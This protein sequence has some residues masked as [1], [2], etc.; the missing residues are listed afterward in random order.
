MSD[1]TQ[2]VFYGPKDALSTGNPAKLIKGT[3]IDAE[4]AAISTAVASK[5][6]VSGDTIFLGNGTAGAPSLAFASDV[7]TGA[8]RIGE[9][10][11]GLVVG[12]VTRVNISGSF[13]QLLSTQVVTSDGTLGAPVYS[14]N[15]DLDSGLYRVAADDLGL[16]AG[17][18]R[19]FRALNA[20][21]VSSVFVGDG[22]GATILSLDG[23]AA[24]T[25]NLR[26]LTTNL[27]RW[28]FV[29]NTTAESGASAG[30]NLDLL[31]YDDAGALL[32]TVLRITRSTGHVALLGDSQE[33]Q[34]GAGTDLRLYHNGTNS[35][36]ENDTG[37]LFMNSTTGITLE[38]SDD[39]NFAR[40]TAGITTL[41]DGV[42][43]ETLQING[44]AAT[45]RA[46]GLYTAGVARWFLQANV[47]AEGGANAGSDL[48]LLAR[49]DAGTA[50]FT[51]IRVI[52]STGNTQLPL[53]NLRLQF[54]NSQDLELY[55]DGTN[56]I[57]ENN[58]GNL[59]LRA[60]ADFVFEE[61]AFLAP[62][63]TAAL[64]QYSFTGDPNTGFFWD[65]ADEIGIAVGGV[66]QGMFAS[67]SFT[68]TLT[69]FTANPT[70]T[71]Q[72]RKNGST[73]TLFIPT[74]ISS[75]SN[76]TTMTMT[77]LPAAIQPVNAVRVIADGL[78]N[79]TVIGFGNGTIAAAGSVITFGIITAGAF[80]F[81]TVGF[82]ASSTKGIEAGW[83][84]T[85]Q[86]L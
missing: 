1:Y 44:A 76:A 7:D 81:N 4:L 73:V 5:A 30:S 35:F 13:V 63:G 21:G 25:R 83:M 34:F 60:G 57:I 67:G 78:I 16:V 51:S 84:V 56:S 10:N 75:T 50:L 65:T 71:V 41:G 18:K 42:G 54:G 86:V 45:G 77:G 69:G 36:I 11:L 66:K 15:G 49:N 38:L 6:D 14:F 59:I 70:G 33:L 28:A 20:A 22:V 31:R 9:N 52:R 48:D 8:F 58:T 29:A 40:F 64:P 19:V 80:T 74:Q 79:N 62:N 53:D 82:T 2:I 26:F 23:A 12:G 39:S 27:L 47:T 37:E 46:V 17:A 3:E 24:T 85:Y 61:G 68:A 32:A 72:W 55:H 43:S